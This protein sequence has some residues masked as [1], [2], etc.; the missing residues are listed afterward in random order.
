LKTSKITSFSIFYKNIS[1]FWRNFTNEKQA[2]SAEELSL[3]LSLSWPLIGR[4]RRSHIMS[5]TDTIGSLIAVHHPIPMV[6]H[7][8]FNGHDRFSSPLTTRYRWSHIL[9]STDEIGICSRG[10]RLHGQEC[11]NRRCALHCVFFLDRGVEDRFSPCC[12]C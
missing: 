10:R 11:V 8:V 9:F 1:L 12:L 2:A 5:S 7:H 4:C 6:A 3:A